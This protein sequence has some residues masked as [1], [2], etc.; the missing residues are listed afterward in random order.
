MLIKTDGPIKEI[1]VPS[2]WYG[3]PLY[4]G[5]LFYTA[6][7]FYHT[8]DPRIMWYLFCNGKRYSKDTGLYYQEQV[9]PRGLSLPGAEWPEHFK[10]MQRIPFEY[11]VQDDLLESG[12]VNGRLAMCF[13]RH[14]LSYDFPIKALH[15]QVDAIGDGTTF[16]ELTYRAPSELFEQYKADFD[17]I[18]ESIVWRDEN[19][20]VD[21]DGGH[22]QMIVGEKV[23]SNRGVVD[24]PT[25]LAEWLTL[26]KQD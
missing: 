15:I 20:L 14:W 6:W 23:V 12:S 22:F 4:L 9:F 2:Q 25:T 18:L 21:W 3:D 26:G 17:Q 16:C 24:T 10:L 5:A 19:E 1:S 11:E 13:H 7:A 8:A